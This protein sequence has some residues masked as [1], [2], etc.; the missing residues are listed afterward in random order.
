M[1]EISCCAVGV[2]RA[3]VAGKCEARGVVVV[4]WNASRGRES[5]GS[6][7]MLTDIWHVEVVA[8]TVSEEL[9]RVQGSCC[10]AHQGICVWSWGAFPLGSFFSF[11][12]R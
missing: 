7:G 5:F 3:V 6:A 2:R 9:K 11:A 12:S 4:V 1:R 10:G 8:C